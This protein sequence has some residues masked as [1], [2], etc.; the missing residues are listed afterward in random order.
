MDQRLIELMDREK[1]HHVQQRSAP[2]GSTVHVDEQPH[3]EGPPASQV[4]LRANKD[5]S[6]EAMLQW[7]VF[8]PYLGPKSSESGIRGHRD[9]F[10]I[11][12]EDFSQLLWHDKINLQQGEINDLVESFISEILP[13]NPIL[14]PV[15]LR[16]QAHDLITF[17]SVLLYNG[18]SC[19]LLVILALGSIARR[20]NSRRHELSV[21]IPREHPFFLEAERYFRAS[22]LRLPSL[23]R[24]S[25]LLAAQCM[26]FTA[27]YLSFTMRIVAAWKAF[28]QAGTHCLAHLSSRGIIDQTVDLA[29][30]PD[31]ITT[32]FFEQRV[33]D[34]SLYWVILK[35]EA[36]LCIELGMA[37]S[38][39]Q[40][41]PYPHTFPNP[42][43]LA[44]MMANEWPQTLREATDRNYLMTGWFYYLG[45]IALKR[46][47]NRVLD[48]RHG[49]S[50]VDR[51]TPARWEE[52]ASDLLTQ[53][54]DWYAHT[55]PLSGPKLT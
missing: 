51:L 14:D 24:E 53:L 23:L 35:G 52:I 7:A 37:G 27:V 33:R 46:L 30:S 41:S 1:P 26:F 40:E 39:L 19:L 32:D 8:Q 54:D 25:D 6:I 16:L 28:A 36:E 11:I 20:D 47:Q 44:D 5:M 29:R 10:G 38:A 12:E 49:G 2:C 31:S 21:D 3:H 42:P 34:D 4:L 15:N 43:H 55:P 22:Q 13:S 50:S 17:N 18:Q 48:A 9:T 45:E